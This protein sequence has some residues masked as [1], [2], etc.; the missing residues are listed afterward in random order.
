MK[1]LLS[2]MLV[3]VLAL[4]F[5]ACG[6]NEAPDNAADS[7]LA[8]ITD[9][10]KLV[11]GYTV[12]DPMNYTDDNGEFV[13]FDTDYAKA[14]CEKL[15]VEPEFVEINWDTKETELSAKN[16]DCIWNG[17]T[18]TEERKENIEFTNPYIINKQVVVIKAAD[19]E[20]YTDTASLANAN[21]VAEIES[22]GEGAIADDAE[23]SKANY[24]AVAKQTDGLL[25]VKSGT[26]DAVVLDYTLASAMVGEGTDYADL[27]I[28]DG[29]D[30]C[31]EEYGI[32]FR[33]GSDAA[34]KVNE[35]TQELIADGTM[36]EIAAKYELS[37]ILKK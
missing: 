19:A 26:A 8:Y 18:I 23:L 37:A 25:E 10:G 11:I 9:N 7:D 35:I 15:G 27:M 20:K 33:K 14:V 4:S 1:K 16:I 32:G 2:I 29:L 24:V 31:V 12:Y 28:I 6:G 13:G 21:L 22:A 34:A 36:D 17:F 5:A 30:L 3:L